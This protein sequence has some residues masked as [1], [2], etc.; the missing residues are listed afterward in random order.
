MAAQ[1]IA[2]LIIINLLKSALG[3]MFGGGPMPSGVQ[4]GDGGGTV[5]SGLGT[6]FGTLGPNFGIPSA[7]LRWHRHQTHHRF[8]W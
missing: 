8:D 6:K 5:M 2:K 3:S 7:L 1:M 4:M